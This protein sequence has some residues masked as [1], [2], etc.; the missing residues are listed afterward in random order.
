MIRPTCKPHR[1]GSQG[2]ASLIEVMVTV[3]VLVVGLVGLAGLHARLQATEF[4]SYQRA[5]A[6]LLVNDMAS[7]M[8]LNRNQAASYV[9]GGSVVAGN[10]PS[11]GSTQASVDLRDWCLALEGAAEKSGGSN[12]GAL[13]GG[14]GCVQSAT[15]GYMVTVAWQGIVPL[16]AP[17]ASV[18]CGKDSYNGSAGCVNDLCR[19]VVTMLVRMATL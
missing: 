12:I 5:Q 16:S 17:P 14:R 18:S 2:G 9:S 6:V 15:D 19:R 1:A 11:A 7:R 3:V 13:I 4:E 8:A 10:C